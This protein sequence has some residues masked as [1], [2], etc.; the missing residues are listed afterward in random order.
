M[1]AIMSARNA[2]FWV[3]DAPGIIRGVSVAVSV[4]ACTGTYPV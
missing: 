1:A 2:E 3:E 4:A